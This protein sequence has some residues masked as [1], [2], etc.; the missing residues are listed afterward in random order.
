MAR[1]GFPQPVV[2]R[3][4]RMDREEAEALVIRLRQG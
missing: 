3:A 2:Q 4:L 1:A